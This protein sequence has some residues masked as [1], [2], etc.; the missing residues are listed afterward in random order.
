MGVWVCAYSS[1]ASWLFQKYL[2]Y[3]RQPHLN[4]TSSG[5]VNQGRASRSEETP[6]PSSE[7]QR[8]KPA[9]PQ[10]TQS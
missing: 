8:G 4:I 5:Q 2:V 6:E 9:T 10:G 1:K 7:N 3:Q